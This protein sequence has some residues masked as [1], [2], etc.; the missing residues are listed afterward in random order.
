MNITV[1]FYSSEGEGQGGFEGESRSLSTIG[2]TFACK[3][4]EGK[5]W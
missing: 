1:D 3:G 5:D 4:S 2:H